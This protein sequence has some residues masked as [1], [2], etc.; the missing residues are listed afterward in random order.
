M[1]EDE[2]QR[3]FAMEMVQDVER[4]LSVERARSEEMQQNLL[5]DEMKQGSPA[6]R[7]ARQTPCLAAPGT[8]SVGK[9]RLVR[10]TTSAPLAGT[11]VPACA[12]G[13]STRLRA[14]MASG[15]E[16]SASVP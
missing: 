6:V 7:V 14:L 2:L 9:M 4:S 8:A 3:S 5:R 16:A 13:F 15:P 11:V 1:W 10:I 12:D